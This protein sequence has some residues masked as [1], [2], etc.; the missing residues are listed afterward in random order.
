M[1]QLGFTSSCRSG[2]PSSFDGYTSPNTDT[3]PSTDSQ[4]PYKLPDFGGRYTLTGQAH[5]PVAAGTA[6][7]Y[8][9]NASARLPPSRYGPTPSTNHHEGDNNS[10]TTADLVGDDAHQLETY[11]QVIERG[12]STFVDVGN[13]LTAIRENRLYR[14]THSTFE[15]YCQERWG[16][17][18]R[19]AT[20]LIDA[21]STVTEMGTMVPTAQNVNERQ[22]RALTPILKEH[23]PEFAASVLQEA[24]EVGLTAKS[25][26][27]TAA[28][29][30]ATRVR[31]ERQRQAQAQQNEQFLAD[32]SERSFVEA[33]IDQLRAGHTLVVNLR[34]PITLV[35]EERGL[36]TR[37]DRNT[38]W[39]NPFVTPDDGSRS[40]VIAA[41]RDYYLPN[42]PS[43]LKRI[44]ELRGRALAC[45]CNPQECHGD[46]LRAMV[47]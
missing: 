23:G 15:A 47:R 33:H 32:E 27:E 44:G 25:I 17:T 37:I 3:S 8:F 22:A 40:A 2:N 26:S 38:I 18:R 14:S 46:V 41:Y 4:Q 29:A 34:D 43:L 11:E 42:K 7:T 39:G 24:A 19:R 21:A 16:F 6:P 12:L 10:M 1:V 36:V 31:A 28:R 30:V 13:A 35:L 9:H 5:G 45:W 20:Y